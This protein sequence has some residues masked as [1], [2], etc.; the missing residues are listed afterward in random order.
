MLIIFRGL[1]VAFLIKLYVAL[2]YFE[3]ICGTLGN[4]AP[5]LNPCIA[6]Q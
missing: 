4:F 5:L 3:E 1:N 2:M 6:V